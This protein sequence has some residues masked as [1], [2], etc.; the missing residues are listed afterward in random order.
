MVPEASLIGIDRSEE[1]LRRAG[2]ALVGHRWPTA[3]IVADLSDP[4]LCADASADV[5]L[6]YN[7]VEC[8]PD[9]QGLLVEVAR[10]L[11]PGGRAI[12]A[13]VDFDSL[14]VAGADAD[15]DPAGLPRLRGRRVDPPEDGPDVAGWGPTLRPHP[16]I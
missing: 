16:A 7:T 8:L 3:E 6:S 12:T 1:A 5:V 15:L 2:S 14:V 13:H 9:P 10:V 11:C 4:L